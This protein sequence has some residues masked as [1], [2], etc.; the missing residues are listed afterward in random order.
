M[1]PGG[2]PEP[3]ENPA[4]T[5]VRELREEI[6]VVVAL[7]D[8]RSRGVFRAVAANEAGHTVIADVFDVPLGGQEPRAAAEIAELRWV[9]EAEA[10]ALEVAPLARDHFLID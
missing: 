9:G 1:Q 8:L 7:D 3:G 4:E 2:K 6:G 10:D 5:L